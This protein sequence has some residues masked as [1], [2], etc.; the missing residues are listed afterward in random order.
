MLYLYCSV[1][2]NKS[3]EKF[4]IVSCYNLPIKSNRAT[5]YFS[6]FPVKLVCSGILVFVCFDKT[7][8]ITLW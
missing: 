2:I 4:R 8:P 6:S 5:S 1:T 7:K 3:K